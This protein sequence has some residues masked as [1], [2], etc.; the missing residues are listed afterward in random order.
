M[1]AVLERH[2][3][4]S[5]GFGTYRWSGTPEQVEAL[6]LALDAGCNL[7]DTA[8]TY[9][10][11][12]AE[13]VLGRELARRSTPVFV[14][15]KAGYL[16]DGETAPDAVVLDDARSRYSIHPDLLSARIAQSSA[17]L[18]RPTL[19]GFLL[20]NP[21]HLLATLGVEGY[22]RN[23]AQAFQ[24]C[25]QQV[26][27][28]QIRFYGVS[29]NTLPRL[30]HPL[31]Q[32]NLSRLLRLAKAAASDHHFRFIQFPHN[33]VE[34][35]ALTRP[36][37]QPNLIDTAAHAGLRSIVNRPLNIKT[38]HGPLRLLDVL[39]PPRRRAT[40]LL[41]ELSNI[42][43]N[44]LRGAGLLAPDAPPALSIVTDHWHNVR[45]AAAVEFVVDDVLAPA[46]ARLDSTP[47]APRLADLLDVL[48]AAALAEIRHSEAAAAAPLIQQARQ[49]GLLGD[50]PEDPIALAA[51]RSYLRDGLDHVLVG[52]RR[53]EHVRTLAPILATPS[54]NEDPAATTT[55]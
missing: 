22:E 48:R 33:L 50:S 12:Y 36:A 42:L 1:S 31:G 35:Q 53:P 6:H 49:A 8:A 19:D 27:Q 39:P 18:R 5:I 55:P 51:C 46:L 37:G 28:G 21:E 30:D 16:H 17:R 25:E 29:S 20:H 38:T 13:L 3:L 9:G 26:R 43:D 14:V 41:A 4:S 32:T 11:G 44:S 34:R 23:V 15:T 54:A 10:D 24:F 40:D 45:T 7:I 52:M 47:L 2:E